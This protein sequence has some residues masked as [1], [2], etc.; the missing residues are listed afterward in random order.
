MSTC[1]CCSRAAIGTNVH[2]INTNDMWEALPKHLKMMRMAARPRLSDI[3]DAEDAASLF[4]RFLLGR[5]SGAS[6][7]VVSRDNVVDNKGIAMPAGR[8]PRRRRR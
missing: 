6:A 5:D 1:R 8:R 3:K 2:P 7:E 4:D